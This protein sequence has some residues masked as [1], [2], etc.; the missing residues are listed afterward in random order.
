MPPRRPLPDLVLITTFKMLTANDQLAASL[1]SPR[2]A[3]LVR[4]A[5]RTVK[6]LTIT[7]QNLEDPGVLDEIKDYI[8]AFSLASYPAMQPLMDIS[9]GE[10]SYPLYP[11]T[12]TPFNHWNVLQLDPLGLQLN[13]PMVIRQ[14]TTIFS[15][16]TD[17]KFN[18][19][20]YN[21]CK[22]LIALLQLPNWQCRLTSLTVNGDYEK[23]SQLGPELITAINGLPALQQLALDWYTYQ[24]LP[25]LT[26]LAQLKVVALGSF[27]LQTLVRS[28][29][30]YATDNA[31]L[32]V[33]LLCANTIGL[34]SLGQPLSSR[35][36]YL[37]HENNYFGLPST[38]RL[39]GQFRFLT[40]LFITKIPF[41]QVGQLFTALSQLHQLVHLGL[42]VDCHRNE[43]EL[44]AAPR[45]LAQMNSL[46]ALELRLTISSHSDIKWLNLP[47]TM[48]NL[49]TIYIDEF[50]C[51]SCDFY[52]LSGCS[53]NWSLIDSSEAL[54][55]FQSSLFTLHSGVPLNRFILPL[56]DEQ[57]STSAEELLLLSAK[58]HPVTTGQ[59]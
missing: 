44:P 17:L 20:S 10:P 48:P 33:Y 13:T 54:P 32:Q 40:S 50:S 34:L 5:N 49:Q 36:V 43:E 24:N 31:H 46:R 18:T 26:I 41:T 28:L 59:P 39:C 56:I 29:K 23:S 16:V 22:L 27:R 58:W 12:T 30:Q 37:G 47:W 9:A 19:Y 51:D 6:T 15:A 45:P 38:R 35:I 55:C 14:I 53:E 42:W 8:N 1:T 3:V 21:G 4:A 52:F 57:G 2:C 7:D 25:D 11:L